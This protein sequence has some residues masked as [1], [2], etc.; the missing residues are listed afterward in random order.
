MEHTWTLIVNAI[1]TFFS[2]LPFTGATWFVLATLSFFIWLFVKANGDKK[3]PVIWEH[4]IVDSNNDRASPYKVG[5]LVGLIVGTWIILTM[6]DHRSLNVDMFAAYLTYLLGGAG[7]N[8][9]A[10]RG[11][12]ST[13][14]YS[15][16]VDE[17]VYQ[18][19]R[20]KN[21]TPTTDEPPTYG[22]SVADVE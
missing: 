20:K 18:P 6:T 8:S 22:P 16:D 3:S 9:F 21:R 11:E 19:T 10:K 17:A 12:R 1:T 5:Y 14:E 15:D 13:Y 4:L 7:V 2:S